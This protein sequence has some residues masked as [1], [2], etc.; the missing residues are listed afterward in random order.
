[1]ACLIKL[2]FLRVGP[3]SNLLM[4]QLRRAK[5]IA[6]KIC[7]R[8]VRD[9]IQTSVLMVRPLRTV[10]PSPSRSQWFIFFVNFACGGKQTR[11]RFDK[12]VLRGLSGSTNK[13]IWMDDCTPP[14]HSVLIGYKKLIYIYL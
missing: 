7:C 4:Q 5:N 11:L 8:L 13:K 14:P 6:T 2:C 10:Y 3:P 12:V 1:M 9:Y